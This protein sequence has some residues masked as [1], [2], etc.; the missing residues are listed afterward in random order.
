MLSLVFAESSL[1]IIPKELQL[2]PSVMSHSQRTEKRP[3]QLLLDNSWH[4]AAMKGISNEIKRGRP[5]IVYLSLLEACS[6]PLYFEN[7]LRIYVHTLDDHVITLGQNVRLP[8]SYHRF[9]GLIAKLFSEKIIKSE[10]QMLLE[11]KKQSFSDLI[12]Q[13][14]ADNV[15]GLSTTGETSSCQKVSS[16]I[17]PNDCLVIGGFQKGHFENETKSSLDQIYQIDSKSLECHIVTAR[18]LYEYEKTLFM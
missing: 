15:I 13:I 11:I 10:D 14:S 17:G 18:I 9:E 8:K 6:I 16:L 5:D 1:E 3:S 7:K 4:F 12:R 2:H